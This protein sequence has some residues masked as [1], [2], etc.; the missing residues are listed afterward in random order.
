MVFFNI[1]GI[2]ELN[3]PSVRLYYYEV[4]FP[5]PFGVHTFCWLFLFG[6][7]VFSLD[8]PTI[9]YC[10]TDE[11]S[12]FC[13]SQQSKCLSDSVLYLQM[14]HRV[15][16]RLPLATGT[17]QYALTQSHRR[18]HAHSLSHTLILSDTHTYVTRQFFGTGLLFLNKSGAI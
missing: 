7:I 16:A 2:T 12:F 10:P 14:L 5:R 1:F 17:L 18:S 6:T 13:A 9:S 4:F 8:F 11:L 15:E 3:N